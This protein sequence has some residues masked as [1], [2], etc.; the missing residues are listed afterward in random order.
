MLV[1]II[2]I[3][4]VLIVLVYSISKLK[5]HPFL[6]LILA[7]I[8]LGLLVGLDVT[9]TINVLLE[10]FGSTMKWIAIVV[11]LGAFIG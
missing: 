3:I 5:I 6:A 9:K 7:A 4:F 11:I 10:G 2:A 8:L 1:N